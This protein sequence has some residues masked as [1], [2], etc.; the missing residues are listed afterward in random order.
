VGDVLRLMSGDRIG[1][2]VGVG[3]PQGKVHIVS[4]ELPE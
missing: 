1:R 3:V 2:P 4:V